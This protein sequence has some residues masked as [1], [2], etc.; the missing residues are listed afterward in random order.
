MSW[1]DDWALTLAV[2]LPVVGMVIVL[3]IPRAE[4]GAQKLVAL[5]TTLVT[6]AVGIGILFRFD[7]NRAGRLQF[8]VDKSWIDVGAVSWWIDRNGAVGQRTTTSAEV[9]RTIRHIDGGPP[10]ISAA[11]Q[12]NFLQPRARA[13]VRST[14][15]LVRSSS[16]C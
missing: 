3:L 9:A 1:F 2:F 4:E 10:S 16:R 5:L 13:F 6:F 14:V 15:S 11:A 12:S 8:G 7:Y